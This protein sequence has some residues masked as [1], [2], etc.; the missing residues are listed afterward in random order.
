LRSPVIYYVCKSSPLDLILGQINPCG[1]D[2]LNFCVNDL[3]QESVV[4]GNG[5]ERENYVI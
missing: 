1:I 2:E 3:I 5:E 4:A